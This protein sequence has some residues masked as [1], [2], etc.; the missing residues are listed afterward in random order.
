MIDKMG[1]ATYTDTFPTSY[2]RVIKEFYTAMVPKDFMRGALRYWESHLGDIRDRERSQQRR[3]KTRRKKIRIGAGTS[4]QEQD[5]DDDQ[6][7]F[8]K[9]HI[10]HDQG[11]LT[12]S[13]EPADFARTDKVPWQTLISMMASL[14]AFM[15]AMSS[16]FISEI[17]ENWQQSRHVTDRIE[18]LQT[19]VTSM[20]QD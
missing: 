19:N 15:I 17:I 6:M 18:Y 3:K 20:R 2:G 1:W 7:K 13:L 5:D 8:E 11:I 16:R 10:D 4:K 14:Q 9:E 12:P